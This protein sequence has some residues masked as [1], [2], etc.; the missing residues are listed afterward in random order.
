MEP[1][2]AYLPAPSNVRRGRFLWM[3]EQCRKEYLTSLREKIESRYFFNDSIFRQIAEDLAP[4]Y[5]DS[6]KTMAD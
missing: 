4:I 6:T 1:M 3:T 5:V 2:E